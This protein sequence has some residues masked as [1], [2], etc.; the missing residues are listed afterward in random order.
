MSRSTA[1]SPASASTT[2][3]ISKCRK[4]TTASVRTA[5]FW[6]AVLTPLLSIGALYGGIAGQ[7]PQLFLGLLVLNVA[8]VVV[9]HDYTP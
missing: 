2:S 5:A 8:F 6:G 4:L 9:G 7:Q 3:L 1:Q